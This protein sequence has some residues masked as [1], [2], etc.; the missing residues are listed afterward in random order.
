MFIW[1]VRDEKRIHVLGSL[2]VDD[3]RWA[4]SR[5]DPGHG[6]E[7]I[8]MTLDINKL[9]AAAEAVKGWGSS[10]QAW[11][12]TREDTAAAVVGH[13]DEDG[14][15]FPVATIDCDQY[16]SGDSLPLAKFY[17]TANPQAILE[18]ITRLEAAEKDAALYKELIYAVG[19]KFPDETRHETALRYIRQ[20]EAPSYSNA[21]MKELEK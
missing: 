19:R 20:V 4:R 18:L 10:N 16:D 12:D 3:C 5:R 17:A 6:T 1:E 2:D 14:R 15:E 9:K 8:E 7:D 21:A 13:V 11:L